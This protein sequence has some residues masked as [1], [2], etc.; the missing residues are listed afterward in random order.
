MIAGHTS[1]YVNSVLEN[2]AK[3]GDRT[4]G[5]RPINSTDTQE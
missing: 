2:I 1:E 5:L 3:T 4:G